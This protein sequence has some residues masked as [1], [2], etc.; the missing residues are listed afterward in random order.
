MPLVF[1]SLTTNFCQC[2]FN[3][4]CF[5]I[6]SSSQKHGNASAKGHLRNLKVDENRRLI[7]TYKV[8]LY[9]LYYGEQV[10]PITTNIPNL[11][12]EQ[13]QPVKGYL[14]G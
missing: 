2:R 11:L 13:A 12:L 5:D 4:G 6:H 14:D 7:W 8:S 9:G 3:R 1:G 10:F